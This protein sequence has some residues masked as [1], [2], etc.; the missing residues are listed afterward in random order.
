MY[1]NFHITPGLLFQTIAVEQLFSTKLRGK[2]TSTKKSTSL[3]HSIRV[4]SLL[5]SSIENYNKTEVNKK[6]QAC[7]TL[8]IDRGLCIF[9]IKILKT[10]SV[11]FLNTLFGEV[12]FKSVAET[13]LHHYYYCMLIKCMFRS[14]VE[15]FQS[16]I[17]L[18]FITLHVIA[19]ELNA[20]IFKAAPK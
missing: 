11:L 13:I 3:S 16:L 4:P 7:E 5:P 14:R 1:V 6:I 19:L 12:A 9:L 20:S 8:T 10:V 17:F 15:Y 18:V 2:E